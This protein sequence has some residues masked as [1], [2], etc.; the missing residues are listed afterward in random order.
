MLSLTSPRWGTLTQAYGDASDVPR[1]LEALAELADEEARSE[2][3]F[4]LWRM[5]SRPEQAYDAAYAAVPHLLRLT[6]HAPLPER[7]QA[8]HLAARTE[9]ARRLPAS[10]AMPSDLV[11]PYAAAIEALPARV[12]AS[13]GEPWT[14]ETA[15]ICAAALLVG[16]RQPELAR[17][18][19]DV[20][21]GPA[22]RAA[23]PF[24]VRR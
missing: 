15:R 20:G 21:A 3:W 6:A 24:E 18:L 4:A 5:L 16:K 10:A 11:E 9:L 12:A 1:L 8:L 23:G 17:S 2:V 19:L 7:A 13:A 14:E 22:D